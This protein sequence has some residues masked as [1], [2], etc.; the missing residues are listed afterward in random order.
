[1]WLVSCEC[2]NLLNLMFQVYLTDLFLGGTFMSIGSQ[3][4]NNDNWDDYMDP[5]DVVFP[6][7]RSFFFFYK[8]AC[9]STYNSLISGFFAEF[10]CTF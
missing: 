5:L 1:M 3:V 6:K 4:W 7:V 2:L 10:I 8:K 9:K